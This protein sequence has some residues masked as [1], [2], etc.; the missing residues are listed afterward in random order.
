MKERLSK[1]ILSILFANIF[2]LCFTLI[3]NFA[4]PK[5]L[6]LESYAAI[7]SFTLYISYAG[8]LH[9]GYEDGMYL[10]YGGMDTADINKNELDINI[11]TL[12]CFQ[13]VTALLILGLGVIAKDGTVMLFSAVLLPFNMT[14]YFRN[15]YQATGE[16]WR[17]SRISNIIVVGLF[18]LNMLLL[19]GMQKESY[20]WY[21]FSYVVV[22]GGVWI[23]LEVRLRQSYSGKFYW[24]RFSVQEFIDNVKSGIL[25][26]LGTFSSIFLTSMDRWCVKIFLDTTAFAEY[27]FAVSMESI[28]NAAVT[29]VTITLYNFFC[30]IKETVQMNQTKRY[31][32]LFASIIVACAFPMKWILEVWLNEY[33]GSAIVI[34][35]LFGSQIFFIVI[36]SI[37]VNQYKAE[38]RQDVYFRKLIS[39]ILFG[40]ISNFLFFQFVQAKEAFAAATFMSAVFWMI[41]CQL[42]FKDTR[43]HI[44]EWFYIIVETILFLGSGI[45]TNAVLGFLIYMGATL[46]M[47]ELCMK[48][49]AKKM[50]SIC[51]KLIMFKKKD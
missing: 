32:L 45:F 31:V 5:Y 23:Y 43:F 39:V 28:L 18:L 47:I 40:L 15:F 48:N 35:L 49:E 51:L 3:T 7:K 30:K 2:N 14:M 33:M 38:K 34:F 20:I 17:Y 41:L 42:D 44:K 13:M 10:R 22:Y 16:F 4:L 26:M 24:F 36:K 29:P 37:Y 12:R 1:G 9:L 50:L 8:F 21:L 19:F 6:P 25:L 11:S 27:S 46:L